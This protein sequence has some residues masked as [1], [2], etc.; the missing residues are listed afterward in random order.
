MFVKLISEVYFWKLHKL[1]VHLLFT[2]PLPKVDYI[3]NKEPITYYKLYLQQV[4]VSIWSKLKY[5]Y[6][7]FDKQ[8][9]KVLGRVYVQLR[10]WWKFNFGV[11]VGGGLQA[12]DR[13]HHRL[14]F[15]STTASWYFGRLSLL[16]E[17]SKSI[18]R[19]YGHFFP[20]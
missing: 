10:F 4:E 1:N 6:N 7:K 16:I 20:F 9:M 8:N 5:L 11:G 15:Q 19:F 14:V 3:V 12:V 2:K 13:F 18:Q 17:I